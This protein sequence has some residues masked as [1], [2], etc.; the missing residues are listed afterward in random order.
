LARCRTRIGATQRAPETRDDRTRADHANR[1][2]DKEL[3]PVDPA[4]LLHQSLLEEGHDD[5]SAAECKASGFEK[6]TEQPTEDVETGGLRAD[7][8]RGE[9]HQRLGRRLAA[10]Q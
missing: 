3:T 10:A 1:D 9:R 6:E 4:G 8:E 5:Q 7:T 2:R